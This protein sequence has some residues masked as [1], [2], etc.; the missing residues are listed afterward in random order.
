L[1]RNRGGKRAAAA[2]AEHENG[3]PNSRGGNP[4]SGE[5][6]QDPAIPERLNRLQSTKSNAQDEEQLTES[7]TRYFFPGFPRK[8]K[9]RLTQND[10][11]AEE[12]TIRNGTQEHAMADPDH[13]GTKGSLMSLTSSP[14]LHAHASSRDG[15][16]RQL[17]TTPSQ[18]TLERTAPRRGA[19]SLGHHQNA[20]PPPKTTGARCRA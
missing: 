13:R 17:R 2:E 19:R 8:S 6:S 18:P 7:H 5:G 15:H 3:Q 12:Q 16:R 10:H 9:E 11:F 14:P 1:A 20:A 4:D